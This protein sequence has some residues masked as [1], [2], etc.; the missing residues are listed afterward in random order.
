[1]VIH[2]RDLAS[3]RTL[4]VVAGDVLLREAAG[5][6]VMWTQAFG[7][8]A[9]DTR[10][11]VEDLDSGRLWRLRLTAGLTDVWGCRLAGHCV[12][13][14]TVVRRAGTNAVS[15]RIDALDLTS[16]K[17]R[18]VAKGPKVFGLAVSDGRILWANRSRPES[19]PL[20]MQAA[21]G[22]PIVS[23]KIGTL[24]VASGD[25][26]AWAQA[27]AGGRPPEVVIMRTGK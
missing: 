13:W 7:K 15:M 19:G 2:A 11:V 14:L 5:D 23:L 24:P 27:R 26:F 22:G 20:F 9:S 18:V 1:M 16:G 8:K 25:I 3:G 6:L 21:E 10:T 12:V 4:T 17:R